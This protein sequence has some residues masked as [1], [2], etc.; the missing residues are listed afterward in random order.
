MA[1]LQPAVR[2]A[3]EECRRLARRHYE[4]FPTAS[5]LV[6]RDKRD[7]LAAIY[8]FARYADDVADEPGRGAQAV[9]LQALAEWRQ[10]LDDCYAGKATHPVFIALHDA[11]QRFDLSR[12]HFENLLR[13]FESDVRVSRHQNF[14]SLLSYCTC[15]ANPVGRLVLELFGHRD[16][17]LFTLSD[18]ICTALQLTNFWQ[19][20]R[21]DFERDRVYLPLDDLDRFHYSLEDLRAQTADGRWRELM[22]FECGRTRELFEQGRALPER[23]TPELRRQL[24]LTWLGGTEILSRIEAAGYDVFHR[25]PSLRK[26]DFL[27][28]YLRARSPFNGIETRDVGFES[29]SSAGAATREKADDAPRRAES[30][31]ATSARDQGRTRKLA[32]AHVTNFYYSFV[33]LPHPKRRAIEA[34]YAFARRGDDI[35]DGNLTAEEAAGAI[36]QHR[37]RLDAAYAPADCS[38]QTAWAPE[39]LRALTEAVRRFKIPRRYFD[40]LIAGME[41]DLEGRGLV[42]YATFD[43]LARYCYHAAGTVGLIAIEIFGYRDPRA[44]DYALNLGTALQLVNILRD[45][46]SDARRGRVYIPR[47]D[48][49]RFGVQPSDLEAKRSGERFVKLMQ[50]ECARAR[51]YFEAAR[52]NLALQDRRSMIAAE[53][54]AAIYWRILRRIVARGY[55]VFGGRVRI[56]RPRK[57]W[58]ALT[59]YLGKEWF[60]EKSETRNSKLE[61]RK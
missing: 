25:R 33:F 11:S 26:R 24:R 45:V 17:E 28:L 12:E 9:R 61:T 8:A 10:K 20:V 30:G 13:A 36:A 29:L 38:G 51:T 53:I 59:V 16:P 23:V 6:P 41:M 3:Y 46:E 37:A 31:A 44:R 14:D 52:K 2:T 60:E 27:R 1:S 7:A 5:R 32:N 49:E 43:D 50:F 56:S 47:E 18:K 57:F 15:S 21:V 42:R 34:V 22:Q 35:V 55:N 48:L 39:E 40:D 54:M 4:N 58:T 19:D